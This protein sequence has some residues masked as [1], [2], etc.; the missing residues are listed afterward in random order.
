MSKPAKQ[1]TKLKK[2]QKTSLSGSFLTAKNTFDSK[3]ANIKTLP[4]SLVPVNGKIKNDIK[5]RNTKN[6]ILEEYYKW[7]FIYG[8]IA[9][10]FFPKDYLGV[11]IGFPKGS[12]TST[13]LKID[14]CIF[15]DKDWIN[16]Y[17]NLKK[18][19]TNLSDL[20]F[21]RQHLVG[22]MEFKRGKDHIEDT[23]Q[24]QLKPAI[25]ESDSTFALGII[26]DEERLFL[27]QKQNGNILRYDESKNPENKNK[28][29]DLSLDL[30]DPYVLIPNYSNL[31]NKV[32][33]PALLDRSERSIWDLDI[34]VNRSS[35]QI[36]DAMS[37]ILRSMDKQGLVNQRGYEILVQCLALKIFDEKRNQRDK[38]IS[39][40]FYI[41]ND[42]YNFTNLSDKDA[43]DFISRIKVL[44]DEAETSYI[45]TL[46][47]IAISWINENRVR[48]LQNIVK[49]LQDYSF[50]RSEKSDL[51]Q[52][53]FYNFAQPFQKGDKA[54][55]LTPL[56]LIDFLVKIV[57]PRGANEKICDPCV[58]IADF[59]SLSYV[60]SFPKLND[61]NL[62]GV[63]I[64]ESMVQ[65]SQLNM[66]L[67]GDGNAHLLHAKDKGSLLY[68]IKKSGELIPLVPELHNNG[69]WDEWKDE[70]KLMK[71]DVILT[72]P[73]FGRGRSFEVLN[74]RDREILSFYETWTKRSAGKLD[75]DKSMDQGI[76]F[77]ENAYRLLNENGR[78]GIVLSN[79]LVATKE[80]EDIMD[81][82][83]ERIRLVAIFDLPEKVF[84]ETNVNPTL[85]VG[86]KPKES[87]LKLL[88]KQNYS[89]FVRTINKIGYEIREQ[90]R[91]VIFKTKYKID[92]LTYEI[93]ID[94]DGEPLVDE[95]FSEIV[96]EFKEWVKTQEETLQ[97]LF[98]L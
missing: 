17:N 20:D 76:M 15:D 60:N 71:F 22:V 85:L 56:R 31:I 91:N 27:F 78:F 28:G 4:Q 35:H 88:Q 46:K 43:Q 10:G 89:V 74:N 97:K 42:E 59:L 82:L 96:E 6:E 8:L 72:N 90:K 36:K 2:H 66:L 80:W 70:T 19:P 55:F 51:Y 32:N 26:Y 18:Y 39:L 25:K 12:K 30:A 50:V 41:T 21:L 40:K 73:P 48:L 23:F 29:L 5:I 61:E 83:S 63:D 67:N 24:K 33:V 11:E 95:E 87:E 58:G 64:D 45:S 37:A 92:P 54:Q 34:I 94:K 93:P 75:S 44:Y 47:N 57:N 79:S 62:W 7:Q 68:K 98:V 81:W 53:V 86:Y 77:L 65:L 13:P 84:A 49:S 69:K 14:G 16:H 1:S 9:S 52:L 38:T 3:Y